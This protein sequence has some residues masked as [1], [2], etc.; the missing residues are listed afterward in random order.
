MAL[1]SLFRLH[2]VSVVVTAQSHN[3][4]ILTKEFLAN[5]GIVPD[6][7]T[8]TQAIN[9]PPLSLL[10]FGV[11]G[12]WLMDGSR[13]F[14]TENC[15][16]SFQNSYQVHRS[17]IEYLQ[18]VG[19]VPYRSLGLN[20][21]VSMESEDPRGWLCGRFLKDGPWESHGPRMVSM[22][23]RF[24]FDIG[25]AVLNLAF[26][27]QIVVQGQVRNAVGVDCNLHHEGP[28]DAAELREAIARWEGYQ[29]LIIE[30]LNMLSGDQ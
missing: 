25:G 20:C 5:A 13:M 1:A 26:S 21:A 6:G 10:R 24:T 15:E 4:S 2:A 22:I 19:Y 27:D 16:S 28:L 23:P 17:V 11:K 12:E 3:P 14:V 18:K 8:I 7:W 9:T 29:S 30:T